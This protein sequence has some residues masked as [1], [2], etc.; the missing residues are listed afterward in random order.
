M[1]GRLRKG[2]YV[3]APEKSGIAYYLTS[4]K[5]YKVEEVFYG[6]GHDNGTMFKI[7]DDEGDLINVDLRDCY[8]VDGDWIVEEDMK[9][10][11]DAALM[12]VYIVI[13]VSLYYLFKYGV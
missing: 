11:I 10:D 12:V 1:K 9:Q 3:V 6:Q 7:I 4:G 5:R 13:F 2:M 8:H